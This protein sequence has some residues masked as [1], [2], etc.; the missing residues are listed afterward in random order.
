[1]NFWPCRAVLPDFVVI[2]AQKCAS[3]SILSYIGQHSG[4]RLPRRKST[5]FFDR[6]FDRGADWYARQFPREW[7]GARDWLTG[8]SCPSYLFLPE[9]APRMAALMPKARLITI[10]RDPVKRLISQYHHE[11]RKGRV[12]GDFSAYVAGSM[13][14][15]WPVSG[16]LEHVLQ[17][18]GVPRGHYADQLRHWQKHFPREQMLVVGFEDLI[19]TPD[20]VMASIFAF[21][22]LPPQKVDTSQVLNSGSGKGE[23]MDAGLLEELRQLYAEK[24]RGLAAIAGCDFS[25]LG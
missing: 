14:A 23:V 11:K 8:E 20:A 18:A 1:M 15:A 2:G 7:F 25:W 19:A 13:T 3:T 6:E 24:N 10:L 17:Q 21:L 12:P 5:H 9:V 16:E 22:G 4:V